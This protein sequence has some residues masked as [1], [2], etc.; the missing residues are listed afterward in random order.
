MLEMANL[1][2]IN[3]H[4]AFLTMPVKGYI[5]NKALSMVVKIAGLIK[6]LTLCIKIQDD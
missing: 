4:L 3:Y 6:M 1:A 5:D 2:N